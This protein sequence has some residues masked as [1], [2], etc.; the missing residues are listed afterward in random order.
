MSWS[1]VEVARYA[2]V[3]SRT[4]RHYDQLGLVRPA[5]VGANGYRY[6]ERAELHLLQEVLVLRELGLSLDAI[7][8]VLDGTTD[9]G[10]VLRA[11]QEALLDERDR[12]TRLA[13]SVGR[14]ITEWEGGE[15]VEPQQ[16]FD[17]FDAE[18][19]KE[20]EADLVERY[21]EPV[22][23][24]IDESH[25]RTGTW[26]AAER[27]AVDDQYA[28]IGR[29]LVPLIEAGAS[30]EDDRVLDVIADHHA[31]VARFWT[32]TAEQY[33][34]LGELYVDAPDFRSR[35]DAEHPAM[36]GYLRDAI[37]A[38]AVHRMV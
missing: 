3:S 11:H 19:Q 17:G 35:Y 30:P 9:R 34:G 24:H 37:A 32:P 23:A 18:K 16:L 5:Y 6:Y 14:T 12:L 28:E 29:R 26:T 10:A 15:P 21:G 2:G 4:L 38:Y 31:V 22:R 8:R 27:A 36:A 1:I 33:A 25:R 13:A 7:G 20:Y